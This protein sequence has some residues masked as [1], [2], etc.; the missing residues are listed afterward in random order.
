[1]EVNDLTDIQLLE[2]TTCDRPIKNSQVRGEQ[3]NNFN[4]IGQSFE[5]KELIDAFKE[6]AFKE[7][8]FTDHVESIKAFLDKEIIEN[9]DLKVLNDIVD[10]GSKLQVR[11]IFSS[12]ICA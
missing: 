5:Q 12:D 9:I 8:A 6:I 7:I 10:R 11:K 2:T 4:K 1:M 3:T